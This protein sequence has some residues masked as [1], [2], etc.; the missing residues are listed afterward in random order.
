MSR[1]LDNPDV[2]DLERKVVRRLRTDSGWWNGDATAVRVLRDYAQVV[3]G[4][5]EQPSPKPPPCNPPS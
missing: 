3:V 4:Q 2:S 5:C 1:Y